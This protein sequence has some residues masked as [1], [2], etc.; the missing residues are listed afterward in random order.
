[1]PIPTEE[2]KTLAVRPAFSVL[3]KR[4]IKKTFGIEIPHWHKSL[5]DCLN[6][7]SL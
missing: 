5:V 3:D 4:K 1:M 6:E 2:Y 7:L